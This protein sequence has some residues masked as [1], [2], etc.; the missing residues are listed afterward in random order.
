VSDIS[1]LKGLTFLSVQG[2]SEGSVEMALTSDAG[3]RFV[4]W[5]ESDCCE[6][7]CIA[8]V[9]GDPGDLL[10]APMLMAEEEVSK[11]TDEEVGE[12]GTW[13]FYK[14]ATRKG[15]VTV[16]WLGTSNGYYSESVYLR[17]EPAN[18]NATRAVSEG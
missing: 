10:R 12:S 2:C 9:D 17:V 16:R 4:F 6:H 5:H 15:Y 3:K 18:D 14:F 7:V 8:Q 11:A 1:E 13:T